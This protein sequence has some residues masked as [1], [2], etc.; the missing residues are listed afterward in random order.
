MI[1][2]D[3]LTREDAEILVEHH[4]GLF[5]LKYLDKALE[6][7]LKVYNISIEEFNS[8]CD[9]FTN[10]ELFKQN[11]FGELVKREDGSP[12]LKAPFDSY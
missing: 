12:V 11:D 4:D 9:D 8:I 7:I 10:Y 3:L 1:R 2:R 6:D 5:P